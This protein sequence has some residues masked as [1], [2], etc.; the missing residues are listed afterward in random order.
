MMAKRKFKV[1]PLSGGFMLT[2]IVG[3]A[4]SVLFIY[5]ISISW[6]VTFMVFFAIM[7]IA[8]LVSMTY[9]PLPKESFENK[10]IYE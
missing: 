2:S 8:S 1:A 4:A 7:F 10:K 3:F 9:N 5:K 6:G